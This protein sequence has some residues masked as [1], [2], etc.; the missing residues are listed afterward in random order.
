LTYASRRAGYEPK[1]MLSGRETNDSMPRW[2]FEIAREG[3]EKKK[4][5]IATSRVLLL[6]LTF[7]ENI[8]DPRSS[9]V[10]AIGDLFK[11]SGATVIACEPNLSKEQVKGEFGLEHVSD[12]SQ[13]GKADCIVLCVSHEAFKK[14]TEEE[15]AK[16]CGKGILVDARGFFSRE[17]AEKAGLFYLGL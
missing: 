16:K 13:A 3:M 15:L 10:K 6:G 1:V 8:C 14:I 7:K 5:N 9:P 11:K 17:K 12:I 4:V 2:I